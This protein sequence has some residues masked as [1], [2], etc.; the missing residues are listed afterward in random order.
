MY[1]SGSWGEGVGL[2]ITPIHFRSEEKGVSP[3]RVNVYRKQLVRIGGEEG[4][5]GEGGFTWRTSSRL[6]FSRISMQAMSVA[7]PTSLLN[8]PRWAL[9]HIF[10]VVSTSPKI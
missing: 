10:P 7:W 6:N 8:S 2:A 4:F 3:K 1:Q 5:G 9:L